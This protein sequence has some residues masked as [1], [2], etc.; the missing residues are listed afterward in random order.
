MERGDVYN[1]NLEPVE[2][3]EQRG[4]RPVLIVSPADFNKLTQ[5]PVIVPITAGGEFARVAGFTVSLMG[6]GLKTEG[7]VRC[8]QPR[9]LDLKARKARRIESIPSEI[10]DLVLE[11]LITIFE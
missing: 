8:D 2:G 3:R 7:V 11:K 5:L 1:A 6:L 9:V 10:M 4:R